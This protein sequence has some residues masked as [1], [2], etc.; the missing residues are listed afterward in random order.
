MNELSNFKKTFFL[1]F[2]LSPL[3]A[4]ATSY[5]IDTLGNDLN[6]GKS[7]ALAWKTLD[8]LNSIWFTA[9]DSIKFKCGQ[10]WRG[11][12]KGK[13]GSAGNY[14]V[15]TSYGSGAKPLFLGSV[16]KNKTSD[17]VNDSTNIWK[18]TTPFTS[19]IGNIIVTQSNNISMGHKKWTKADLKNQ[20]DFWYDRS[21]ANYV[22]MFSTQNPALTYTDIEC[23]LNNYMVTFSGQQYMVVENLEFKYGG[24]YCI[25]GHEANNLIFQNLKITYMGGGDM[26]H[27]QNYTPN[28]NIRWGNAIE[29][30]GNSHDMIVR[31][32]EIGEMYD[33]GVGCELF[34]ANVSM[35]N[36]SFYNNIIYNSGLASLDFFGRDNTLTSTYNNI[37]FENNTCYDAGAGWGYEERPDKHGAQLAFSFTNIS[38]TNIFFQNNLFYS[39]SKI[40][41]NYPSYLIYKYNKDIASLTLNNNAVYHED[42][43]NY[44]AILYTNDSTIDPYVLF[45]YSPADISTFKT[46]SKKDANSLFTNPLLVNPANF[47][48]H[49]Q[50][51]SP[52]IDAGATVSISNDFNNDIRPD[53]GIFDIGAYEKQSPLQLQN[54]IKQENDFT[55]YPNPTSGEFSVSSNNHSIR[56]IEIFNLLGERIYEINHSSSGIYLLKIH[57]SED[58]IFIERLLAQ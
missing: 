17:W 26:D 35:Y 32:N 37:H 47:D 8:K 53:N 15:F 51:N 42:P 11:S 10:S 28:R 4:S 41:K 7:P 48:F 9:G 34:V 19:D 40:S 44:L 13:G 29:F 27:A 36:I 49:L 21:G 57:T 58:A 31:N 24:S 38:N 56:Q 22:M 52:C 3:L 18:C 55:I 33:C 50:S 39:S 1:F 12:I 2:L 25:K 23:A 20:G 46:I 16:N 14:I 54:S 5:Y 45:H 30:N 6:S 43:L